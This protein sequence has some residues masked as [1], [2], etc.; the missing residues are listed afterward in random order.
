MNIQTRSFFNT[1]KPR[2]SSGLCLEHVGCATCAPSFRCG[3]SIRNMHIIHY[4][5]SGKGYYEVSGH[6][7]EVTAGDA[8][9]IYPDDLV[10]YYSHPDSPWSLCW[11]CFTDDVATPLMHRSGLFGAYVVHLHDTSFSDDLFSC[12][13]YAENN[14]HVSQIMLESYLLR[15][16]ADIE[17]S[18]VNESP[19][20]IPINPSKEYV[21]LAK[22]YIHYHYADD[23]SVSSVS[24]FIGLERSYFYRIFKQETGVS[25]EEYLIK[26]RIKRA[27]ELLHKNVNFKDIAQSVGIGDVYYFSKVFK[28]HEGITPSEYREQI[29]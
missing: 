7:Y 8:F 3:P 1:A 23:I 18:R 6:Q 13:D 12:L 19:Q 10:L 2:I 14:D 15:C 17:K 5:I 27:K 24:K 20:T 26:C 4:V 21:D 25:P 11:L 29:R 16:I 9:I 22:S 28:K